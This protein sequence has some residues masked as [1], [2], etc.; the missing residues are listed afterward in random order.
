VISPSAV[1]R[2]VLALLRR[3]D[4]VVAGWIGGE[5]ESPPTP[6][7]CSCQRRVD[8]PADSQADDPA[9]R[10]R[11]LDAIGRLPEPLARPLLL[12]VEED[13]SAQQLAGRLQLGSAAEARQLIQRALR[14]LRIAIDRE[15]GM[16]ERRPAWGGT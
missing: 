12:L 2:K 3:A 7:R 14:A 4:R 6:F 9:V 5:P 15:D 16:D 1:L 13:L 11:L 10:K 8:D